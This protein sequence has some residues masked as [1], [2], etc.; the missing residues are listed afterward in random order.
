MAQSVPP[1][2]PHSTQSRVRVGYQPCAAWPGW[3]LLVRAPLA[4]YN[5]LPVPVKITLKCSARASRSAVK[6]ARAC[7]CLGVRGLA[8]QASACRCQ[9]C[10]MLC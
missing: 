10:I 3:E 9:Y 6:C 4:V 1:P 7:R 8:L 5:A 2:L